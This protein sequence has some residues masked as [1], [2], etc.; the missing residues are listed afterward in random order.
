MGVWSY[1]FTER[2]TPAVPKEICYYIEG[3]LACYYFQEAM[4]LAERLDTTSSKSNIQ[5][6]VTAHSRKEWQDR[7]QQLSKE[8]PGAQDHRTSP[9]IWEGCS[10][11]PLQFIGGYDNFMHHARMKHNVGQQRNV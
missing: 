2:A 4:N 7:L 11:K 6:E 5:V 9:V 10:G 8:I 1:F 3:F